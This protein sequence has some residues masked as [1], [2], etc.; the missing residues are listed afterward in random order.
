MR[1]GPELL[2]SLLRRS[3]WLLEARAQQ[4]A[5]KRLKPCVDSAATANELTKLLT[6]RCI[7]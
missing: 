4:E 1:G 6:K 7:S 3:V 5:V 2:E